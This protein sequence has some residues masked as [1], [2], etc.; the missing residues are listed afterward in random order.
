MIHLIVQQNQMKALLIIPVLAL[1]IGG[2]TFSRT[3]QF[4]S[5]WLQL[6]PPKTDNEFT[7]KQVQLIELNGSYRKLSIREDEKLKIQ[8][9]YGQDSEIEEI[10]FLGK[11]HSEVSIYVY[12]YPGRYA[13]GPYEYKERITELKIVDENRTRTSLYE[14]PLVYTK[15][16]IRDTGLGDYEEEL[17]LR[18]ETIYFF[19]VGLRKEEAEPGGYTTRD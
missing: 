10:T 4:D 18:E 1:I 3:S 19:K 11:D 7:K 5:G 16:T 6:I 2:C 9:Q 8:I 15:S 12:N 13:Y 14:R 17:M